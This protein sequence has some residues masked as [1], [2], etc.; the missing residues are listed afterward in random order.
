MAQVGTYCSH[1]LFGV[2]EMHALL[3]L[4]LW[5]CLVGGAVAVYHELYRVALHFG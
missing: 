1:T 2:V 4:V 3:Q 5:A